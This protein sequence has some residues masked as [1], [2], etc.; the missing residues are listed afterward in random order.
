M[1]GVVAQIL[2]AMRAAG[3]DCRKHPSARRAEFLNRDSHAGLLFR[4]SSSMLIVKTDAPKD[5]IKFLF[6][7]Q[8][9][10][11]AAEALDDTIGHKRQVDGL[12]A[13]GE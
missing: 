10:C 3:G 1:I 2:S 6:L 4:F 5:G 13:A 12:L 7:I 9:M 8:Q 11:I